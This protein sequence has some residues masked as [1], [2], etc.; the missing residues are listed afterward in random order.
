M[1]EKVEVE[2]TVKNKK[3][4]LRRSSINF[5]LCIMLVMVGIFSACQ[6][7]PR[8]H[9]TV[10]NGEINNITEIETTLSEEHSDKY[11]KVNEEHNIYLYGSDGLRKEDINANIYIRDVVIRG[12]IYK[13]LSVWS[14]SEIVWTTINENEYYP[15]VMGHSDIRQYANQVG[16]TF[17][18]MGGYWLVPMGEETGI[19]LT[20]VN[21]ADGKICP[22]FELIQIGDEGDTIVVDSMQLEFYLT[23]NGI[24]PQNASFSKNEIVRYLDKLQKYYESAQLI[25]NYKAESEHVLFNELLDFFI[26]K[27]DMLAGKDEL[28]TILDEISLS[29]MVVENTNIPAANASQDGLIVG[30][31]SGYY[32][33]ENNNTDEQMNA[34][35]NVV[36]CDDYYYVC[37][38]LERCANLRYE[39]VCAE[40]I[41]ESYDLTNLM[42]L[43]MVFLNEYVSM[44]II[45]CDNYFNQIKEITL[46]KH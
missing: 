34:E 35:M 30:H 15:E 31:Y 32:V 43:K 14:G 40:G 39:A 16:E 6:K 41:I 10:I 36:Q 28:N 9:S 7:H 33:I 27:K 29:I 22:R 44:E 21:I 3:K 25:F 26:N 4:Y 20:T 23:S 12:V 24:I 8:P 17:E 46:I 38:N 1:K 45:E 11:I 37:L 19:L 42:K 2:N 18:R 5:Q 13:E